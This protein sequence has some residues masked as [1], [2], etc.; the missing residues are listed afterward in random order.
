LLKEQA[1]LS[2]D[3]QFMLQQSSKYPA[4]QGHMLGACSGV[5]QNVIDMHHYTLPVQV[6]ENL[7]YKGLED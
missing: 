1:F 3:V 7:I 2:L 4:H 6:P 5:Y